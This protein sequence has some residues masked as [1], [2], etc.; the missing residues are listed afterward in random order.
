MHATP[1]I[2]NRQ[3]GIVTEF[4][5]ATIR[6]IGSSYPCLYAVTD[7]TENYQQLPV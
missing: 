3:D 4:A 6:I 5:N 7:C 2:T 1:I